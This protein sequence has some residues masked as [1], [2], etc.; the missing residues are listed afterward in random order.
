[1]DQ[2]SN[3]KHAHAAPGSV[4][5]GPISGSRKVY[6]SPRSHPEIRVPFREIALSDPSEPAVRVYDPSGPYTASDARIDLAA[7]LPLVREEW[8]AKRG[9]ASIAGRDVRARGQRQCVG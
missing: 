9:F 3:E 2:R 4:T 5:T 1:M 6:A 7:G 8:I